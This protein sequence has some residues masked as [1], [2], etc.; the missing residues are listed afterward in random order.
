MILM[1]I[2]GDARYAKLAAVAARKLV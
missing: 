2:H 1:L